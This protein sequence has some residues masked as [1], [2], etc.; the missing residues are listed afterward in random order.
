MGIPVCS[1]RSQRS[2]RVQAVKTKT[3]RDDNNDPFRDRCPVFQLMPIKG[4]VLPLD[5]VRDIY[6]M[7]QHVKHTLSKESIYI[8]N[9]MDMRGVETYIHTVQYFERCLRAPYRVAKKQSKK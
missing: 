4:A 3:R 5:D 7:C 1:Q 8:V 2:V 9:N 6:E